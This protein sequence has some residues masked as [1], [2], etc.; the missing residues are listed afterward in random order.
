MKTVRVITDLGECCKLWKQMVPSE[1]L[2]DLW[3]VRDCFQRQYGHKP[4]FV[5]CEDSNGVCGFLPLSWNRDTGSYLFFPGETW[6]G[7]TWLEHNRLIVKDKSNLQYLLDLVPGSY[8]LRYLQPTDWMVGAGH[9]VDEV[10]YVFLPPRYNFEFENYL[11]EFSG[12]SAKRLKRELQAFDERGVEFVY[13]E[14]S[15][16]ETMIALNLR[17]YGPSSYF[18]DSRFLRS[19]HSLAHLL[20]AR[21][22]LRLTTVKVAGKIAAVDMGCIYKGIYTLLAGGT[23]SDF[24]GVAKLI[25]IHHM[26]WACENRIERVDFLCGD[27]NWKTLFHLTPSPLYV[28]EGNTQ[29]QS[30][31]AVTML[32][33][34]PPLLQWRGTRG[35]PYA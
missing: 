3:E 24:P 20:A 31:T 9:A 33:F 7:K 5:V 11:T 8:C 6:S 22:W 35:V 26:K 18:T 25:N 23:H 13:N 32:G 19:F 34:H 30:S 14:E 2:S 28:I 10:G 4:H 12:K 29:T 15:D 1:Q 17:S 16:F 27:F 21:K